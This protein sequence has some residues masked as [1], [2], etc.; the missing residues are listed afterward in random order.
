MLKLYDKNKKALGYAKQYKNLKIESE[1]SEGDKTLSFT[2]LEDIELLEEYYI[3]TKTDR[4]VV[5]ERNPATGKFTEYVAALDLEALEEPLEKF[6][7]KEG[8]LQEAADMALVGSGWRAQVDSSLADKR[9]N[10]NLVNTTILTVLRKLKAA[11]FCEIAFDSLEQIVFFREHIGEERGTYFFQ[12]LN[13]KSLKYSSDTYEYYTRILPIG[14][15]GLKI[16]KINSEKDYLENF[17]YSEKI[18]TYLWIAESYT[19]AETLKEDAEKKL[20]DLS[21]P[22]RSYQAELIDLAKQKGYAHLKFELG[23]TITLADKSLGIKEK[24]RI[25]KLIEYPENPNKNSCELSNTTLSFEELQKQ[26]QDAAS[27]V[28]NITTSNGTVKGSSV[29]KIVINQ[30]V[31][32]EAEV[33]KISQGSFEEIEADYVYIKGELGAVKAIIGEIETNYLKATEA[34]LKYATIENLKATNTT[35]ENLKVEYGDFKSLTVEQLTAT[36]ARIETISGDL[37]NYKEIVAGELTAAKGWMLESSIGTAQIQ[38]LDVNKLN[39]GTIDTA[40]ISLASPDS[41]MQ[42]TGSQILINDTSDSLHPMNRVVLGKYQNQGGIEYGFLVRSKDGQTTMIDGDGV[43]NAGITDGSIDNNKVAED[44]NISGKKL[45]IQSVVT[46][47]NEGAT[48]ISQTMIQ[49]GDKTLDIVLS[50]KIQ[51][52]QEATEKLSSHEAK[53]SANENEI[54]LRVTKEEYETNKTFVDEQL[55]SMDSKLSS[56]ETQITALHNQISLKVE[57]TDIEQYVGTALGDYSTTSQMVAAIALSKTEILSTVSN[58]YTKQEEFSKVQTQASQTAEK[59]SWIVKSGTNETDFTLTDRAMQLVTDTID[60]SAT[61]L[62]NIISGGTAKI[63]AQNIALEGIVTANNNFKVLEDGSIEAVK[64]TFSGDIKATDLTA[65]GHYRLYIDDVDLKI[66]STTLTTWMSDSKEVSFGI[67]LDDTISPEGTY[68][69]VSHKNIAGIGLLSSVDFRCATASFEGSMNIQSGLNVKGTILAENTLFFTNEIGIRSYAADLS[70]SYAMLYLSKDDVINLGNSSAIT[71]ISGSQIQTAGTLY[72][73]NN[74]VTNNDNAYYCKAKSGTNREAMKIDSSDTFLIGSPSHVTAIRGSSVRLSSAT[75][76]V[77]TSDKRKKKEIREF[78]QRHMDFFMN[79]C[80]VHFKMRDQEDKKIRYGFIAQ[81]V[82]RALEKAGLSGED[83][84]GLDITIE[85]GQEVYGL[86]Y[87]QF[88]PL[89][90]HMIQKIQRENEKQKCQIKKLQY[91]IDQLLIVYQNQK[92]K[93]EKL[94]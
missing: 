93:L 54:S 68:I 57:Q 92:E 69:T 76:T 29:D 52:I 89:S 5:K 38:N 9:R 73:G 40:K 22:K 48:K 43:H 88:I 8:T 42:I 70:K 37:A 24:Q 20:E 26:L 94:Y 75:G 56:A 34:D 80:A 3:E 86:I 30:I 55:S 7:V 47:I 62:V 18:R 2:L 82:E 36:S 41:S 51:E 59:F 90:C 53:I 33:A 35:I 44:A 39:A 10:A 85:K 58:T 61:N 13:L 45:D 46:E 78:D 14:A 91:Q 84:A 72:L 23:D 60:L 67:I 83:F 19:D 79:L 74:I 16:T 4:Y 25:V 87:E 15:D 6:S 77:V 50:E 1:L 63:K 65:K 49:V 27:I 17:Q 66:I 32:F 31:D 11:F 21:K 71:K 12:G 81:E 28:E 64:G